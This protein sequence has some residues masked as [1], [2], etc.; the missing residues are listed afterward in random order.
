MG[1]GRL[2]D[3]RRLGSARVSGSKNRRGF[4][5]R[6]LY[7]LWPV[8]PR[9]KTVVESLADMERVSRLRRN[10]GRPRY[11]KLCIALKFL[12][13]SARAELAR[14]QAEEDRLK[15]TPPSVAMQASP[16]AL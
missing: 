8:T 12:R 4:F 9:N 5:G 7:W 6:I 2:G 10:V 3:S 13:R 1:S 15:A 14:A 16:A 11:R